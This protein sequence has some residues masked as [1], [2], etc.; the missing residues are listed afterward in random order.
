MRYEE[1]EETVKPLPPSLPSLS[2]FILITYLLLPPFFPPSFSFSTPSLFPPLPSTLHTPP[3]TL[4]HRPPGF[5]PRM[6]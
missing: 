4:P 5:H 1:E 2:T 6:A 3:P